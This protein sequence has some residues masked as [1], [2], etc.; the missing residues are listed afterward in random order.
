M[1]ASDKFRS[2][3]LRALSSINA[4]PENRRA[5]ALR[6]VISRNF[7]FLPS[8]MLDLLSDWAEERRLAKSNDEELAQWFC[9]VGSIFLRN[10]DGENL[11]PDEWSRIRDL[12]SE[13]AGDLDLETLTY[14]LDLVLE[15]KAL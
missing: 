7:S 10:Y 13:G 3:T 9:I 1:N 11:S 2:D 12:A 8:S 5:L 15:H 6:E 4:V 14:V